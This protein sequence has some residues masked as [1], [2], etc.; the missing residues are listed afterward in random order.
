MLF[1][2]VAAPIAVCASRVQLYTDAAHDE[3]VVRALGLGWTG[4]FRALDVVVAHLFLALPIGTRA[5]RAG[6]GSAGLCGVSGGLLF[7]LA[8][9]LLA[10]CKRAPV[11][12]GIVAALASVCASLSGAWIVES[13]T[14]GSSV[15]GVVLGL[16]PVV[17]ITESSEERRWP[18]LFGALGLALSYEPFVGFIATVGSL[19]AF[20]LN[21]EIGRS[22]GD[23]PSNLPISR[24]PCSIPSCAVALAAGCLPFG[25]AWVYGRLAEPRLAVGAWASPMGEGAHLGPR[26][27]VELVG[28]ELGWI[29]AGLCLAGAA[30]T[31]GARR[32]RAPGAVLLGLLLS[33]VLAVT[34]GAPA[35]PWRFGAPA[36]LLV[37]AATVLAG[38]ALQW[39]VVAVADAKVPLAAASGAMVLL[40]ALT[41]PVLTL[42]DAMARSEAR[43]TDGTRAWDDVAFETLPAGALLLVSDPALDA[44][45]LASK[46]AGE[47]RGDLCLVPSFDVGNAGTEAE[48]A[49]APDLKPLLRDYL[50][51]GEARERTLSSFAASRPLALGLVPS[52]EHALSRH[53]VP[54]GLF[55]IFHPEPR[56]ASE[57]LKA[58]DESPFA[59]GALRDAIVPPG[60]A[61]LAALTT[62][63]L[64][65]RV[66]SLSSLGE[67]DAA[68]RVTDD[69]LALSL[70]GAK[71][72]RRAR[73]LVTSRFARATTSR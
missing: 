43:A 18:M 68:A 1:V 38:V 60:D 30:M 41:F 22:G 40:L 66:R 36:L 58:I 25:V 34:L 64:D 56:G 39:V 24:S 63:L 9:R 46:A 45:A 35:G 28:S 53:L 12:N 17:L 42:D 47:L 26:S 61:E 48:L 55:A 44:R 73:R 37:G 14:A 2:S 5:L 4:G 49:S 8:R 54:R 21:R 65:A 6:L 33:S 27:V 15:L 59:T 16:L 70:P 51:Y 52:W 72:A 67:K 3:A 50:L 62:R 32:S 31:L 20:V 13:S 29:L 71:G 7:V 23:R 11:V 69:S 19:S 57:R 10:A